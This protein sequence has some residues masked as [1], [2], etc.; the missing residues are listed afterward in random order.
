MRE[1][2]DIAVF[3]VTNGYQIIKTSLK[4]QAEFSLNS[5]ELNRNEK[6]NP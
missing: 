4:K 6:I 3:S 2:K 1:K 5:T